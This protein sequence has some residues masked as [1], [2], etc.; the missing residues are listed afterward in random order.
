M[1]AFPSDHSTGDDRPSDFDDDWAE[2]YARRYADRDDLDEVVEFLLKRG[3][4]EGTYLDLCSGV[5]R[6]AIPLASRAVHVTGVDNAPAM[7]RVM[8]ERGQSLPVDTVLDDCAKIDIGRTFS[9]A[10]VTFNSLF[11]LDDNAAQESM[12]AGVARHLV[13]GGRFVVETFV[14]H[15]PASSA[16]LG[17]EASH[18]SGDRLEFITR[19]WDVPEQVLWVQRMIVEAPGK[20]GL[21]SIRFQYLFP[22]QLDAMAEAAGLVRESEYADWA[23]RPLCEDSDNRVVVYRLADGSPRR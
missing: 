3:G 7:L 9:L 22:A 18:L 23:E 19:K 4:D 16:L 2:Q 13:P 10:Y 14:P 21:R 15:P 1:L 17:P 20:V 5:G 8:A 12:L 6:I 11:Q